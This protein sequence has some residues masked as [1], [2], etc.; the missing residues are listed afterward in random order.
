MQ[1]TQQVTK[2]E[3]TWALPNDETKT[4]GLR[5]GNNI[6]YVTIVCTSDAKH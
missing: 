2:Q 6:E 4:T 1:Q 5:L 3:E